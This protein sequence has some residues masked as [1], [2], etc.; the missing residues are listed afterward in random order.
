MSSCGGNCGCA[1][2]AAPREGTSCPLCGGSNACQMTTDAPYKGPCWCM[3]VEMPDSLLRRVP[4][5]ERGRTCIC[6]RC[7][8]EARRAEKWIPKA[9]AGEFYFT[10]DGRFVFTADYHLRRG[11]CCGSGCRH[12]PFD[13]EG[14][15]RA[16]V[17]EQASLKDA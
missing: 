15:P 4:S 7:V 17:L 1:S 14:R 5:G 6:H 13:A 12:C 11:Y 16:E 8:A 9:R 2:A 3:R 10:E